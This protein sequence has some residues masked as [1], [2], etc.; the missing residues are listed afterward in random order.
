[1][2]HN[3]WLYLA[4]TFFQT[5]GWYAGKLCSLTKMFQNWDAYSG[6]KSNDILDIQSGTKPNL[7]AKILATNCGVFFVI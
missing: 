7:V 5:F 3:F 4:K 2:K 1:M 6:A